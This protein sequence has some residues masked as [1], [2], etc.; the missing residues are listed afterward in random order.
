MIDIIKP[1]WYNYIMK[2]IKIEIMYDGLNYF[3][4]Q[5]QPDKVTIQGKIENALN[6]LFKQDIDLIYAGRTDKG[7][8]AKKMVAN[9]LVDTNI[10]PTK[11]CF[12]LNQFLP[13]DI[14]ILSSCE[15]NINFN[16]RKCAKN[17]TYCYSL[18]VSKIELPLYAHETM[19]KTNLNY[20]KMKKAIKYLKGTHDY[21]SFVTTSCEIED[22]IR[23]ISKVKL[24][25]S[26]ENNISHY[27]FY[28]TGNGFLYN[29]VRI[30][31]GTLVLVGLNKIKPRDI[32]KIL[33]LKDRSKAGS[34]MPPKGLSLINVNYKNYY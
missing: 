21:T 20:A 6:L 14:K 29:Q 17:K 25:K 9:F 30:M 10:E 15:K 8:S 11:I 23:K 26:I 27:D 16:S 12:A 5:K 22:K 3:G 34:V 28:F 33:K 24:V 19:F 1:F 13:Q 18:Y 2:N 32:K 4:F 7:V 31:V